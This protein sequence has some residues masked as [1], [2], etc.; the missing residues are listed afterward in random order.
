MEKFS[1]RIYSDLVE[2]DRVKLTKG[3][4][5]SVLPT[6]GAVISKYGLENKVIISLAHRHFDL[7]PQEKMVADFDMKSRQWTSW[8]VMLD[9][10]K[11]IP[12]NWKIALNPVTGDFSWFP[13]DFLYDFQKFDPEKKLVNEI[14][15]NQP[16]LNEL[17]NAIAENG[18]EAV[19]GLALLMSRFNDFT[20]DV[21]MFERNIKSNKT[22]R[23]Y[24]IP[25]KT[26]SNPD[27]VTQ[28][29]FRGGGSD[30]PIPKPLRW[31]DHK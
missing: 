2:V 18:A 30:Q 10:S 26:L 17:S 22:S 9:E 8:P 15:C 11:L 1:H 13:L 7:L 6:L 14:M 25:T 20:P 28:W 29:H 5:K 19:F 24:F 23:S 16:F 4:D 21:V 27:A 31:C 12:W 3:Y